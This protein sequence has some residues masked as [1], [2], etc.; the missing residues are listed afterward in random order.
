MDEG[1]A[2][3]R[4]NWTRWLLQAATA[5]LLLGPQ[6]AAAAEECAPVDTHTGIQRCKAGLDTAQVGQ[7]RV[8]QEKPQ[9]CWAASLAM[10]FAHHG[11]RL[12]IAERVGAVGRQPGRPSRRVLTGCWRAAGRTSAS[13][14]TPAHAGNAP[15]RRFCSTDDTL[16]RDAAERPIMRRA[17]LHGAGE[18]E[19][20][21]FAEQD[22]VAHNGGT[23]IEPRRSGRRRL[24]PVSQHELCRCGAGATT[25][26]VAYATLGGERSYRA[27]R[28]PA[29][30]APSFFTFVRVPFGQ[31]A[32]LCRGGPL[33]WDAINLHLSSAGHTSASP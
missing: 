29:V 14:D 12:H 5:L 13:V 4:G 18:M 31:L 23:V 17:W 10:V 21:R 11:Y 15:A 9:W 1:Q 32:V 33:T 26:D 22:A 19:Y 28:V 8:F 25:P 24:G 7:I 3:G 2:K 16:S 27:I 20:E 30:A 6:L